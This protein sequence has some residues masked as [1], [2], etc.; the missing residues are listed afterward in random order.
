[1]PTFDL[2]NQTERPDA[3]LLS[4]QQ[5]HQYELDLRFNGI[6]YITREDKLDLVRPWLKELNTNKMRFM[7]IHG[8]TGS[9][10][11]V[12]AQ[13][14]A[15]LIKQQG[16]QQQMKISNYW[17][18]G[19]TFDEWKESLAEVAMLLTQKV[20]HDAKGEKV[21]D[22]ITRIQEGLTTAQQQSTLSVLVLDNLSITCWE[23]GEIDLLYGWFRSISQIGRIMLIITSQETLEEVCWDETWLEESKQ[24]ILPL[25]DGFTPVQVRELTEKQ[26]EI[27]QEMVTQ[28]EPLLPN[29]PI[30]LFYTTKV[31]ADAGKKAKKA[32]RQWE[33][34]DCK[35]YLT[36]TSLTTRDQRETAVQ[37]NL[38]PLIMPVGP[39]AEETQ[40]IRPKTPHASIKWVLDEWKNTAAEALSEEEAAV[41]WQV[42]LCCSELAGRWLSQEMLSVLTGY[43][44]TG[45]TGGQAD[46]EQIDNI[47]RVCRRFSLL[48][49]P[50]QAPCKW[51]PMY[52]R[53]QERVQA[54]I[55]AYLKQQEAFDT[56]AVLCEF[57]AN[58][59]SS[60]IETLTD[61][62][63][64]QS[65]CTQWK[66]VISLPNKSFW[67]QGQLEVEKIQKAQLA[68]GDYTWI[69]LGQAGEAWYW[70]QAAT[71]S[72]SQILRLASLYPQLTQHKGQRQFFLDHLFNEFQECI[73]QNTTASAN[74]AETPPS[75]Q[76]APSQA[77]TT[78]WQ[79]NALLATGNAQGAQQILSQLIHDEVIPVWLWQQLELNIYQ[80]LDSTQAIALLDKIE[81]S[82]FSHSTSRRIL[83]HALICIT[84]LDI[85]LKQQD[86]GKLIKLTESFKERCRYHPA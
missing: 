73:I 41:A 83:L 63:L 49:E 52:Y 29:L 14:I 24:L 34:E 11:T 22:I 32:R 84:Q 9:G 20:I 36:Q 55:A 82:A 6:H 53:M 13:D 48:A 42:L 78:Y 28:I 77:L 16:S 60:E 27:K 67:I 39:V 37:A 72:L 1:P 81:T 54:E 25:S 65:L 70:Y 12:L 57:F 8:V 75:A 43:L 71:K 19:R 26:A 44:L 80:A 66:Q 62:R 3:R 35:R 5:R 33:V 64:Q 10:K 46:N 59:L 76:P 56:T 38:R 51:Q 50:V 40:A 23:D 85:L 68:V 69:V 86:Y 74:K 47:V 4:I 61:Y 45:Q 17:L 30:D 21:P 58:Y 79:A 15:N 2:P 31:L 7:Y 18:I